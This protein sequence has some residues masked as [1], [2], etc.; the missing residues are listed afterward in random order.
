MLASQRGFSLIEMIVVTIL[1]SLLTLWSAS[2][3]IQQAEDAAAA[4]M[5]QWLRTLKASVDTMLLRQAD[6]LTGLTL[7]TESGASFRDVFQ[8]TVADLIRAGYLAR[9]FPD[10]PPLPFDI[11]IRLL[12][13]QGLCLTAGCKIEA[14]IFAIP[15]ASQSSQAVNT[16]LVG[17]ILEVIPGLAASVTPLMPHKIRGSTIHL[18]NPPFSDFQTLPSG[19]IV[20]N[21]FHD[22]SAHAS[23]LRQDER[24]D[25]R[26]GANLA[27]AGM[28]SAGYLRVTAVENPGQT[29]PTVG[30]IAQ[31]ARS[32]LVVC[33]GGVWRSASRSQGGHFIIQSDFPTPLR[34]LGIENGKNPETGD[35][36]C[37]PGF[38]P[39]LVTVWQRAR[40][41]ESNYT[42]REYGTYLCVEEAF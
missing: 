23:F 39:S 34:S 22:T 10:Q 6:L 17:K 42:T 4:S 35:H 15:K 8:P 26:L 25:V 33:Q 29:C 11:S 7:Q 3:W 12:R 14:Y 13:P 16:N 41:M 40:D 9:S 19:T 28:S 36:S 24:R 31:S 37:P 32:G 21:A 5:G 20:L 2:A 30:L 18:P 1:A 27:V 38:T